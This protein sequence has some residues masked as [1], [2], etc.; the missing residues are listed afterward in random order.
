MTLED[1][2]D[3]LYKGQTNVAKQAAKLGI[4]TSEL[5]QIFR[6]Y[7]VAQKVDPE[8]WQGDIQTSWPYIT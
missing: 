3:E 7:A 2:L 8:V 1:A 6:N 4:P 5:Q